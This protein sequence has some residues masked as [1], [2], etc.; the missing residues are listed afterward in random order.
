MKRIYYQNYRLRY[1]LDVITTLMLIAVG[2]LIFWPMGVSVANENGVIDLWAWTQGFTKNNMFLILL[3]AYLIF[4]TI[5]KRLIYPGVTSKLKMFVH[6]G[7]YEIDST[8]LHVIMGGK[9]YRFDKVDQMTVKKPKEYIQSYGYSS[10]N[11][12]AVPARYMMDGQLVLKSGSNKMSLYFFLDDPS[13]KITPPGVMIDDILDRFISLRSVSEDRKKVIYM[14][15]P[16]SVDQKKE[17][18]K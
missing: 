3:M 1:F 13:D 8:G 6:E 12:S 4:L 16:S 11:I 7:L 18:E 17:D 5:Y 14:N 10:A 15:G 2:I 9:E